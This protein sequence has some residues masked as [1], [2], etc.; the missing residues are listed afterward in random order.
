MTIGIN[1]MAFPCLRWNSETCSREMLHGATKLAVHRVQRGQVNENLQNTKS[2]LRRLDKELQR[3]TSQICNRNFSHVCQRGVEEVY[4]LRTKIAS[5]SLQMRYY[6]QGYHCTSAG[7]NACACNFNSQVSYFSL[8][9]TSLLSFC[10]WE[11]RAYME[12][13]WLQLLAWKPVIYI[14]SWYNNK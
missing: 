3:Q 12:L 10:R 11:N 6:L 8:F 1:L 9:S 5:L 7:D 14:F 2:N 4:T 13:D